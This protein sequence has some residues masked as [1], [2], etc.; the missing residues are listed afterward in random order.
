MTKAYG[1]EQELERMAM[2]WAH[3]NGRTE[4]NGMTE[5]H[6]NGMEME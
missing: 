5:A 1:N 3:G 6:G 4:G 2:E